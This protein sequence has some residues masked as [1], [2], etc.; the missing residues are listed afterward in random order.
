MPLIYEFLIPIG[1]RLWLE[2]FENIIGFKNSFWIG[3]FILE[4]PILLFKFLF[5]LSYS[6]FISYSI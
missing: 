2:T 5:V 3:S 1:P 6:D 4:L